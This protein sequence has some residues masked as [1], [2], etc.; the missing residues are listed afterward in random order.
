MPR[1]GTQFERKYTNQNCLML[2]N[3][4]DIHFSFGWEKTAQAGVSFH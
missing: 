4:E 2:D 1:H 3:K